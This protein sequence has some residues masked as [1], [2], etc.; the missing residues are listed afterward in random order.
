MDIRSRRRIAS[1]CVTT[2]RHESMFTRNGGAT[3]GS[4]L[5][6]HLEGACSDGATHTFRT[7]IRFSLAS[8]TRRH[9][10]DRPAVLLQSGP[11]AG[12]CGIRRRRQVTEHGDR[13]DRSPRSLVV[14]LVGTVHAR[15]GL[16]DR[17]YYQG[18]HEGLPDQE[19]GPGCCARRSHFTR[20]DLRYH[21]GRQRVDGHLEEPEGRSRQRRERAGRESA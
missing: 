2:P 7:H 14:S 11:G 13:Q 12:V 3:F 20:D 18:L 4:L 19:L 6:H 16:A 9:H 15:D 17:R 8:C 10:V 5:L 21:D 1:A